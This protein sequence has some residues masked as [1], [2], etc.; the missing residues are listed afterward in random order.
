MSAMKRIIETICEFWESG[1]SLEDI[2][3]SVQMPIDDVR[4][5]IAEYA[6]LD[7]VL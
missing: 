1:M 2:S 7:S 5:V 6:Y 3:E 4:Y